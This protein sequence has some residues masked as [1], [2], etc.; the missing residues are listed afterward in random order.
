MSFKQWLPNN[1][2]KGTP[3]PRWMNDSWQEF[4]AVRRREIND[5][6]NEISGIPTI[7]PDL[8]Y[9]TFKSISS[10]ALDATVK[11]GELSKWVGAIENKVA[12]EGQF[13]QF[14]VFYRDISP[15]PVF[16]DYKCKKCLAWGPNNSQADRSCKWVEG[17]ISPEGWCAIWC[18]NTGYKKLTWPQELLAGEW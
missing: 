14:S 18:P 4:F 16:W 13:T 2:L 15:P 7:L 11:P 6:K 9:L 5:I 3:T 1:P 17:D 12:G 10:A 8:F